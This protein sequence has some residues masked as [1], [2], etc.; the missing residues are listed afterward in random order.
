MN[1]RRLVRS[2][3]IG[4]ALVLA[5]WTALAAVSGPVLPDPGDAGVSKADQEKLGQQAMAEVYKQMPVLPD[6]SPET[7]YVRRLGE[8]L[9]A[10]IPAQH[11]WP[12]EFHVI[13]QK[14]I[15]AFALPG[16]PMF[17]NLGTIVAAKSEAQLAGVMAHEMAHVYMQ[18]SVKQMK[19]NTAP[20]LLAGLGQIA[21]QIIG[22]FGGGLTSGLA[23]LGGGMWSM[24]YSRTDET[25][26]DE[27]GAI[28]MYDAGYDPSA[29]AD[30]FEQLQA[31]GDAP[32]QLL[33]D[34]P[35]PGNRRTAIEREV[36]SWPP[37]QYR[38]SGAVFERVQAEARSVRAYTAKEIDAG[39]QSGQWASQNAGGGQAAPPAPAPAPAAPAAPAPAD[40]R[41]GTAAAP[42][43]SLAVPEVRPTGLYRLTTNDRVSLFYPE[44][45]QVYGHRDDNGVTIAPAA[46]YVGGALAYGVIV[47]RG[48]DARARTLDDA[49]ADLVRTLQ[50]SN[51][52]L[53]ALGPPEPIVIDGLSGLSVELRG[54][55][56][57]VH[58]GR[59][60]RERD[61]LVMF[62][63]SLVDRGFVYLLF[64]APEGDFEA[65]RPTY[66]IML[67]GFSVR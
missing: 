12:W 28:I 4:P 37:K 1:R 35:N 9:A 26:A 56:P 40:T 55:S 7:Q 62:R 20:S 49:A 50:Q 59:A 60:A 6:S 34:H 44:N 11:S 16:G 23:Q 30:F 8:R 42:M 32:P 36:A 19:K 63:D 38:A 27:V 14:E 66:D 57:I 41:A 46:G 29:L 58:G 22:G 53:L 67:R 61:W 65:L 25:Q 13:Q 31:Q 5:S 33:S 54:D 47:S 18:H 10:V 43:P 52:N 2:C 48:R 45:W 17:V 24:K 15:N 51:P 3:A 64:V 39:A 21:G